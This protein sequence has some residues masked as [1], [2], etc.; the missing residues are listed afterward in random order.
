MQA[1]FN[2]TVPGV[3][4]RSELTGLQ[5]FENDGLDVWVLTFAKANSP[6]AGS[7]IYLDGDPDGT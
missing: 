6:A 1:L 4:C 7:P 2:P 3:C 5:H